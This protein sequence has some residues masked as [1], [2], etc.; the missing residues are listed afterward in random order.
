MCV[1]A[2]AVHGKLAAEG[3]SFC[4]ATAAASAVASNLAGGGGGAAVG[5]GTGKGSRKL[6]NE[7]I[8]MYQYKICPFCNKL[9]A[10]MDYLGVPYNVTE[11]LTIMRNGYAHKAVITTCFAYYVLLGTSFF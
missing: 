4:A 7:D 10:V 3:R 9:K 6:A 2:I 8:M 11:V 1:S 5:G